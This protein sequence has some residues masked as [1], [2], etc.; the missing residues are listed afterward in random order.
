MR[1]THPEV[2]I[3]IKFGGIAA[4]KSPI[5]RKAAKAFKKSLNE[6]SPPPEEPLNKASRSRQ[7]KVLQ[8]LLN[9]PT[10]KKKVCWG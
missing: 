3:V 4:R 8:A 5:G 6:L 2:L 1:G 7:A 10:R 9:E